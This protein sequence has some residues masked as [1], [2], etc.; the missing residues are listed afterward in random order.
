VSITEFYNGDTFGPY[1]E[2]V[3]VNELPLVD[4]RDTVYMYPG[5]P[6]LLD[7]GTGF[8]SYEWSTGE[9]SQQIEVAD[10]GTYYIRVQNDRC[11]FN[12][13][14]AVVMFYDVFVPNA[15]RP[16]GKN[17]IF[18]AYPSSRS[19]VSDFTMYIFNR[20][21]QQIYMIK[22]IDDGWDGRINGQN[23]PGDVYVWVVSF[24]VDR[25]G[26]VEKQTYKGNVIL[27]R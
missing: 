5:S 9:F 16:G 1:T 21:G 26:I 8:T 23:A 22:N 6:I 20:W 18:K 4:L 27:L 3:T 7:A 13:D 15:F 2:T 10:T 12:S 11:C 19:A 24:N 25:K 17:S 14:S